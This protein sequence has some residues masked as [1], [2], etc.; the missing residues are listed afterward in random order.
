[1]NSPHVETTRN[2]RLRVEP[3]G[4]ARLRLR[5]IRA[6]LFDMDGTLVDSEPQFGRAVA[7]I[8]TQRLGGGVIFGE[9]I[10]RS[11][12]SVGI[13]FKEA[14]A[15]CYGRSWTDIFEDLETRYPSMFRSEGDL[16]NAVSE[17]VAHS[18]GSFGKPIEEAVEVL[19]R[20]A[21]R[22]PVAIVS[23][24]SRAHLAALIRDLGVGDLIEFY[25]GCEDYGQGKPDPTCYRL[26]AR[27]L[28]TPV[29]H[30]LVFEDSTP[31][32]QAAKSAGM[33]CIAVRRSEE[34]EQHLDEA[35]L[36]VD[37]FAS[38]PIGQLL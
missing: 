15:M 18:G 5:G 35:D 6:C 20:L 16:I 10:A 30:C 22:M 1:M 21:A 28:D 12:T 24:S 9:G 4:L 27:M 29:R 11:E 36:V 8:V 3:S 2:A 19:R 13:D 25:L 14:V 38:I 26:A 32:V 33:G 17:W 7:D 34:D 31:G 23:G 37:S